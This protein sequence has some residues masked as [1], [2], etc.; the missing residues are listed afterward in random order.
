MNK[1]IIEISEV[2]AT[3]KNENPQE[4][5]SKLK[6]PVNFP[7]G[8]VINCLELTG[9]VTK[10]KKVEQNEVSYYELETRIVELTSID[11]E[12][13]SAYI[14]YSERFEKIERN[15]SGIDN[16]AINDA[17]NKFEEE[18]AKVLSSVELLLSKTKKNITIH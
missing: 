2:S 7:E 17:M 8:S 11:K 3:I 9:E 4:V 15:K 10:C 18:Y 1:A 16:D 13:L 5:G 14:D 6:I 12:I